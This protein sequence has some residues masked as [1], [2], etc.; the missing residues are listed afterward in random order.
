MEASPVVPLLASTLTEDSLI[1]I[2]DLPTTPPAGVS[3]VAIPHG[4][5][6][7]LVRCREI[8]VVL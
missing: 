8:G 2:L 6:T 1:I 4:T 7:S 3:L 5:H